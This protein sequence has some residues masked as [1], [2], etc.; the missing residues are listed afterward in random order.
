M[1]IDL[2]KTVDW[3]CRFIVQIVVMF[4]PLTYFSAQ[5]AEFVAH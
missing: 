5:F 3:Y 2:V 4:I 1:K